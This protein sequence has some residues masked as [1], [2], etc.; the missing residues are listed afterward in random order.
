MNFNCKFTTINM[1]IGDNNTIVANA[2]TS[3]RKHKVDERQREEE[4][5]NA[6]LNPIQQGLKEK[7]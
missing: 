3:E 5:R 6:L 1:R 4:R 2:K 7:S